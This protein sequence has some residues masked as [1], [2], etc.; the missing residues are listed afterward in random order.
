MMIP[1]IKL[2]SLM[3]ECSSCGLGKKF[4]AC[5]MEDCNGC[6]IKVTVF[7]DVEVGYTAGKKKEREIL[8]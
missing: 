1:P 3:G 7:E 8:S 4:K 2:K 5:S 6:V